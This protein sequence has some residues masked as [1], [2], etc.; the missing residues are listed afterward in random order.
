MI[1]R[2]FGYVQSRVLLDKQ[3]QLSVLEKE[4]QELD[5]ELYKRRE[6][7]TQTRKH[8]TDKDIRGRRED[9]MNRTADAY[10][11]YCRFSRAFLKE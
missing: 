4:L 6:T 3:N 10:C 1:Y 2:R 5:D 11:L 8:I 9:L 7:W